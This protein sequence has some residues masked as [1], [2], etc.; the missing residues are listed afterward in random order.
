VPAHLVRLMNVTL[1]GVDKTRD[2]LNRN[3]RGVLFHGAPVAADLE[4][5][6]DGTWIYPAEPA[7]DQA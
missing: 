2:Y 3:L 5:S 1:H 6:A 4:K 7:E